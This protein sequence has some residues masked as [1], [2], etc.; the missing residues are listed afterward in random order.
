LASVTV[1]DHVPAVS[2]ETALVPSPV[3]LPGVQL[4][5]LPPA[6]PV[7]ETDAVPVAPPLHSTG[8][9]T[10]VEVNA[11]GCVSVTVAIDE[12]PFASV[13]VQVHEPAV[14]PV[15][16]G[17]PS[18]V[19]LP[20]VQLYVYGPVPPEAL[21]V[22][23]PLLPPKQRIFAEAVMVAVG[24]PAF[25]IVMVRV[26]VHPFASVTT[27]TYA[28]AASPVGFDPLPEGDHEYEYGPTPP[29]TVIDAEPLL[30]PHVAGV[31]E[32]VAAS[33]GGCVMLNVR[34]AV[35]PPGFEVT[36][37]VYTPAHNPVALA[38]VP[39][40]GAHAYVYEPGPPDGVTLAEPVHDPLQRIFV[41][42]PVV[43]S[44]GGCVMLNVCVAVHPPGFEVT[45]TVYTPAHNPVALAPVPPEGAHAYVYGPGPPVAVTEA[46]PLQ[47]LLH[48]TLV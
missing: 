45:V 2:P 21:T 20:G 10:A 27:T 40:E 23:E 8:V 19:G 30:F 5:V 16:E 9:A 15:T 43:V 36:V 46:V 33:A 6:P 34:V 17:V 14:R 24:E 25:V 31:E 48:V 3:G 7:V 37:T 26:I 13:T 11:G 28:P 41:C 47:R 39:P 4:Y 29:L 12:Q 1:T 44:A 18:P 35:H 22:A 32:V 42:D 38:P